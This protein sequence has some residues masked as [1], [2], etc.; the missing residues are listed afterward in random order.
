MKEW[1]IAEV[2]QGSFDAA[3]GPE[4]QS[5]LVGDHDFRALTMCK[6]SL[7]LFGE[8]MHVDDRLLDPSV[9]E[10]IEHV[11]DERLAGNLDERFGRRIG[12]GPHARA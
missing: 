2:R 10:P 6:M 11:I 4:Q 12:Q 7:Q 5:S 3:T 9:S 8:V 1:R